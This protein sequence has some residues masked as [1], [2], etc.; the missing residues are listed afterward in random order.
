MGYEQLYR[1]DRQETVLEFAHSN[2]SE[3]LEELASKARYNGE[4]DDA[5]HAI[6]HL[7]Q[8]VCSNFVPKK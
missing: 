8:G 1:K 3:G 4:I 2:K 5:R 7:M 6:E